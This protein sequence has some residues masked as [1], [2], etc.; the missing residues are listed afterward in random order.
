MLGQPFFVV[1]RQIDRGLLEALS[2]DIVPQLLKDVPLQPSSQLLEDEPLLHRFIRVFDR[3]GYSPAFFKRM[4]KKHRIACITY[5]KYSAEDWPESEFK[6]LTCKMPNEEKITMKLAER[7]TRIGSRK[8]ERVWVKEVRKLTKSGHQTSVI[9]SAYSLSARKIAT[10]MFS[11]WSQENFFRYMK[12][13]YDMDS[14]TSYKLAEFPGTKKVINPQWKHLDKKIR[15]QNGKLAWKKAEL[16][17]IEINY[18]E[19]SSEIEKYMREKGELLGVIDQMS[20]EIEGLKEERKKHA[21]HIELSQLPEQHQIKML[22]PK[23]KMFV[24]TIKMIAYRSE[25][26][27]AMQIKDFLKKHSDARP[28]I[29]KLMST[30]ADIIPEPSSGRLTVQIHRMNNPRTDRAVQRLL[31]L[32][33]ETKTIFPQ[34][35]LQL[36]YRMADLTE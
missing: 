6:E 20:L 5:R 24:D 18:Q 7:G 13:H 27:M 2:S 12:Q 35:R 23:K 32:L 34:T 19:D 4:W 15:S 22:D 28:L 33:N 14:L 30:E 8:A 29:R 16:G 26:A 25:T 3:E 9:S 11:R 10:F 1:S 21:K 31:R 36:H 17:D